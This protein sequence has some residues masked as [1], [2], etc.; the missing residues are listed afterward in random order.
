MKTYIISFGNST[1]YRL[2]ADEASLVDLKNDIRKYLV[3]KFPQISDLNF[4]D[5]MTV[6]EVDSANSA[7]YASYPEFNEKSICEIKQVLSTEVHDEESVRNLNS[8]APW[9]A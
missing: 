8:N 6:T 9:G 5:K 7:E 4:F 1:K 3:N 2:N